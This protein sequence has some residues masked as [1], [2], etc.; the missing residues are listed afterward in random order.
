MSQG[1]EKKGSPGPLPFA[2]AAAVFLLLMLR[3]R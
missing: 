2:V 1:T 3:K